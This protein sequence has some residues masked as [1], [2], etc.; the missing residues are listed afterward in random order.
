MNNLPKILTLLT[1]LC[2]AVFAQ[3]KG[4]FKD[5][6]N[7]KIYKTVKIDEQTW[8]AENL[9]DIDGECYDYKPANCKKYNSLL[10]WQT[11][12][13]ACPE[14]WHLPNNDEWQTLINIAGG[15]ENAGKKLKAKNGW[16]KSYDGKSGNG[17][18]VYGFAALPGG[19]C[20]QGD[21][22]DAGSKGYWWSASNG[23]YYLNMST[24]EGA[25]YYN[26][27]SDRTDLLSVRC[28]KD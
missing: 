22:S 26:D 4:T 7:G 3:Q 14:G 10:D 13:N 28:L 23:L 18:D 24:N 2:T 21:C 6:R 9:S 15:N 19:I 20:S 17:T 16:D 1:L 5:P 27:D 12:M 11:A 25:Y 8:M